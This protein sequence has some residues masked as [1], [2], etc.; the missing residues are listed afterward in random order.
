MFS[1][2]IH[3]PT[4][5]FV[6]AFFSAESECCSSDADAEGDYCF[7]DNDQDAEFVNQSKKIAH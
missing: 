1:E 5:Q 4:C 6:I 7:S 3:F 2:N